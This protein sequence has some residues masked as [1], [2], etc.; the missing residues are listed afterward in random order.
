MDKRLEDDLEEREYISTE[1][2]FD[3]AGATFSG[4]DSMKIK[5][6]KKKI[7]KKIEEYDRGKAT[8][9]LF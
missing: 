5:I 3:T 4:L 9:G 7:P 1:I 6:K 2:E 8:G